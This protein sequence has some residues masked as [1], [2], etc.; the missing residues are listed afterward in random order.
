M[1][2]PG[3][4]GAASLPPDMAV[5]GLPCEYRPYVCMNCGAK[6]QISTNHTDVCFAYCEGCSWHGG[7]DPN[8]REVYHP[9]S[10]VFR[11]D[12]EAEAETDKLMGTELG[13]AADRL[14]EAP[15][16]QNGS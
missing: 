3:A 15:P 1:A 16:R 5:F 6:K 8:T 9:G 13:E 12:T 7:M 10:R 2:A 4:V 11:F 14:L